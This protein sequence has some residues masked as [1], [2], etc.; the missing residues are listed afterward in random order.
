MPSFVITSSVHTVG[1]TIDAILC[2]PDATGHPDR[3]S[4]VPVKAM[5]SER[6]LRI[7]DEPRPRSIISCRGENGVT[8]YLVGGSTQAVR[9]AE[10]RA[11]LAK[12]LAQLKQLAASLR[13]LTAT[14]EEGELAVEGLG[15]LFNW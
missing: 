8:T 11:A 9:N 5:I 4:D 13:P 10:R 12:A 2:G 15:L 1:K 14:S 3:R 7:D 6:S